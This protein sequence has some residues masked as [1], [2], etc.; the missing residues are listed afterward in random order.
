MV[1]GL[2]LVGFILGPALCQEWRELRGDHFIIFY[3]SDERFA[4]EVAR[5]A[6]LYYT[7]IASDLG[8]ARYSNF[9]QWEKRVKIYIYPAQAEF[10]AESGQ[11]EWSHGMASYT[12][13]AIY[14][15]ISHERF[16]ESLL[17]HEI[18]HLIFR[19]FVG[20]HGTI[21]LWLDEGVAQWEEPDKRAIAKQA[22]RYLI[23][24]GKWIPLADL[25]SIDIRDSSDAERVQ[26]FYMQAVSLVDYLI[27]AYGPSEFTE[28]C[29][30]L[31]DGKP[32]EA[33]L[34]AAYTNSIDSLPELEAKLKRYVQEKDSFPPI[35]PR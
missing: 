4:A 18:T 28:F 16:L 19:D 7:Q 21:P 5:R 34:R 23:E 14:T 29:R 27:R 35:F 20:L 26:A 11:P 13:K 10:L 30:E 17:P 33:A 32:L 15:Y 12:K 3:R 25:T 8:Y 9:W 31:R 24:T 1:A 2:L 22:A 6:E